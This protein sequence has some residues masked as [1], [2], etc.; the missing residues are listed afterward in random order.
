MSSVGVEVA[1]FAPR[2]FDLM[3]DV[4]LLSVV[5]HTER[6][7]GVRAQLLHHV[8]RVMLSALSR[9][10]SIHSCSCI[11]EEVL[12]NFVGF[13]LLMFEPNGNIMKP[14][15]A[16]QQFRAPVLLCSQYSI[17]SAS[18]QH[19]SDATCTDC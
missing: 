19:R 17:G 9:G 4:F 15:T 12:A 5:L 1:A 2:S 6:R 10:L 11:F 13:V 14:E 16:D 3:L 7:V 8:Q 18:Y